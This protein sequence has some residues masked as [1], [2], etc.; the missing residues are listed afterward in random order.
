MRVRLR[1]IGLCFC[2]QLGVAAARPSHAA[3]GG[4]VTSVRRDHEALRATDVVTS[5][6]RYDV[7]EARNA[8]DQR[9]R[10]YVDRTGKVFAVTW[11]GPRTPDLGSLLGVYAPRYQLAARAH[12]GGHHALVIRDADFALSVMRLPR[13][14]AGQALLPTAMPAGVSRAEIR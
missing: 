9:I 8:S 11:Q 2:A 14:W 6:A 7:H 10:E 3:L 5:T 12:R 13:G 4:D 1:T